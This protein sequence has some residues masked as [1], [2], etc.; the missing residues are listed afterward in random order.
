M[1]ALCALA[2]LLTGTACYS[3]PA[4]EELSNWDYVCLNMENIS[5][6]TCDGLPQPTVIETYMVEYAG[7]EGVYFMGEPNIFISPVADDRDRTIQHEM[8]HYIIFNSGGEDIS[9]CEQERIVRFIAG[10]PWDLVMKTL[11]GCKE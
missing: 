7:W 9:G 11:Y 8:G 6:Y 1:K 3:P 10:Q 5:E 2:I 4:E